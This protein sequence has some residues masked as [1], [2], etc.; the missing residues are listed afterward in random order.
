MATLSISRSSAWVTVL[1]ARCRVGGQVSSVPA[2]QRD[3]APNTRAVGKCRGVYRAARKT[4]GCVAKPEGQS[5]PA[6]LAALLNASIQAAAPHDE[7][8]AESA[9]ALHAECLRQKKA[10]EKEIARLQQDI[11]RKEAILAGLS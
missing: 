2:H 3:R 10:L 9:A 7:V 8:D 5:K 6:K 11:S 4:Q 1:R